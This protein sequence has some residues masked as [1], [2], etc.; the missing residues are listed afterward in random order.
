MQQMYTNSCMAAAKLAKGRAPMTKE[1]MAEVRVDAKVRFRYMSVDERSAWETKYRVQVSRRRQGV[2]A[3]SATS[4]SKLGTEY[5]QHLGFGNHS[6]PVEPAQVVA[7]HK[8]SGGFPTDDEVFMP[9][10]GSAG[11]VVKVGEV[12]EAGE[13]AGSGLAI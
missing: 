11:F 2:T 5:K 4:A 6:C 7:F 10:A 1:E 9:A 13:L 12:K 8:R 3:T